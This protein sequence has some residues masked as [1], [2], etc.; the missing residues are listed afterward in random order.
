MTSGTR[1]RT[2]A[3]TSSSKQQVRISTCAT[4]QAEKQS[5]STLRRVPRNPN[6]LRPSI[7][8]P[9]RRLA[10]V[11]HEPRPADSR[12]R[13]IVR[14]RGPLC[15]R[16]RHAS[17]SPLAGKL[18][19]PDSGRERRRRRG[20]ARR[21][22]R[23]RRRNLGV[24]RGKRRAR[25]RLKARKLRTDAV[26]RPARRAMSIWRAMTKQPARGRPRSWSRRFPGQTRP[27]W[28]GSTSDLNELTSRVSPNGRYLAFMSERSLTGYDNRDAAVACPD[29]EVFLYD[30]SSNRLVCASCDPT[31]AR[32]TGIHED[33]WI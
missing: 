15:L 32:P 6:T 9:T 27:S 14:D 25:R 3:R 2:T 26:N 16:S 20:R 10:C 17:G 5:R 13:G 11:L 22:R 33:E 21:H 29:E 8:L 28:G 23:E 31:G 12:P 30:A 7:K 24:F 18:I 19:G 4:C 1:C